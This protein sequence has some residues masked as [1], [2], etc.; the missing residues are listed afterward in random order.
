MH[1]R[2]RGKGCQV[3]TVDYCPICIRDLPAYPQTV[4]R[5]IYSPRQGVTIR[6]AHWVG[7]SNEYQNGLK[8]EQRGRSTMSRSVN[9]RKQA[10]GREC[11]IRVPSICNFNSE[12]SVQRS[13]TLSPA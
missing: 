13:Y 1:I 11:T 12:T 3:E 8:L 7:F 9:L 2:S 10:K 4:I 6:R 5:L